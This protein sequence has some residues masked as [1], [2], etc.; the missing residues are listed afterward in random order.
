MNVFLLQAVSLWHG[1]QVWTLMNCLNDFCLQLVLQYKY[2]F[3]GGLDWKRLEVFPFWQCYDPQ[4][5]YYKLVQFCASCT[6]IC[7]D[8][9]LILGISDLKAGIIATPLPPK[10][11]F[12]DDPLRV[13]RAVRFGM[14]FCCGLE[15]SFSGWACLFSE[16]CI[17]HG[18]F[19]SS[20]CITAEIST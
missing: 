16:A 10:A 3:C 5:F 14:N 15:E 8:V 4:F 20:C 17:S 9:M 18:P 13:L 19:L 11:T 2:R 1:V 7:E 12:L 6:I